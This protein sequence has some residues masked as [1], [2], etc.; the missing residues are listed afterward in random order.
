MSIDVYQSVYQS[1]LII[2]NDNF[3]YND[4]RFSLISEVS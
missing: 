4:K 2:K 3:D 1:V